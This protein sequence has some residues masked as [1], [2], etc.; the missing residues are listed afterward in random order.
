[1]FSALPQAIEH[2]SEARKHHRKELPI[3]HALT[4]MFR[5][6][7][8]GPIVAQKIGTREA[9]IHVT[10]YN[11]VVEVK[12]SNKANP[13]AHGSGPN[14]TQAQQLHWYVKEIREEI[15]KRN[16]VEGISRKPWVG[17]LSDG[18]SG[19][20][21]EWGEHNDMPPIENDDLRWMPEESNTDVLRKIRLAMGEKKGRQWAPKEGIY[22]IF[23][24]I[25]DDFR[26][27]YTEKKEERFT[28]TKFGLWLDAVRASGIAPTD[29]E[30]QHELF[31]KHTF[32][33][34]VARAVTRAL[35]N[36]EMAGTF[37]L[38]LKDGFTGWTVESLR[39]R[40]IAGCLIQMALDY[41]WRLPFGD[42]L[43]SYIKIAYRKE[44]ERSTVSTTLPI[45]LRNKSQKRFSMKNGSSDRWRL[46][47]Q[48]P[49]VS[50]VP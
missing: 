24:G 9:D 10:D 41:D 48:T 49:K 20:I 15:N 27:M 6:L 11:A 23:R 16:D 31:V 39:G 34:A 2:L 5:A 21:W 47:W 45:G 37:A 8:A 32:L 13:N 44:T 12:A 1:M 36:P 25:E 38:S 33:V 14:E 3:Q 35:T 46:P 28:R 7:G 18:R 50:R 4:N 40:Q 43:G 26:Q 30:K 22:D 17:I 19:W 42:V 29:H